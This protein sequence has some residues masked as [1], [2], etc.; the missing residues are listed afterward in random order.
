MRP[1]EPVEIE[2]KL[3]EFNDAIHRGNEILQ[4][5]SQEF[6]RAK[7]ARER[8]EALATLAAT[9]TILERKAQV[10]L[11]TQE[12]TDAADDAYLVLEHAKRQQE[13]N[14]LCASIW[15]TLSS[16]VREAYRTAGRGEF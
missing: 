3:L 13:T 15:Q 16:S 1:L 2:Q 8:A 10:T 12:E 7:R 9:G 11:N 5:A 6:Y 4:A 14:K